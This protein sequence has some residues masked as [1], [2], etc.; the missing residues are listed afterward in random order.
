MIRMSN[1]RRHLRAQI[2]LLNNELQHQQMQITTDH[3]YFKSF[4][5]DYRMLGLFAF[6]LS[7]TCLGWKLGKGQWF[8]RVVISVVDTISVI[9]FHYFKRQLVSFLK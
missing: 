2:A 9:F 6:L 1:S 5:V 7:F 8:R 4:R 3:D